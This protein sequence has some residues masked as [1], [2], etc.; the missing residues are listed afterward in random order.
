MAWLSSN[1]Q[2]EI[3]ENRN[4]CSH[5]LYVTGVLKN[6]AKFTGKYKR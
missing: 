5:A 2:L 1:R 3:T 6:V 4:I